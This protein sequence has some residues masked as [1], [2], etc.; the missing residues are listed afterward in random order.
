MP[1]GAATRLFEDIKRAE[2]AAAATQINPASKALPE[3]SSSPEIVEQPKRKTE[4]VVLPTPKR[5]TIPPSSPIA[6]KGRAL[7]AP[8]IDYGL[9]G[10]IDDDDRQ[11]MHSLPIPD[12]MSEVA[13]RIASYVED[14]VA[15][16]IV[17]VDDQVLRR[18]ESLDGR[19]DQLE[20]MIEARFQHLDK[21]LGH[22]HNIIKNKLNAL[23]ATV[24]KLVERFDAPPPVHSTA[25]SASGTPPPTDLA[26][27]TTGFQL[28]NPEGHVGVNVS[29]SRSPSPEPDE[30]Q[31]QHPIVVVKVTPPTPSGSQDMNNVI[32]ST[33]PPPPPTDSGKLPEPD[34]PTAPEAILQISEAEPT[35]RPDSPIPD[36]FSPNNTPPANPA[37]ADADQIEPEDKMDVDPVGNATT[38]GNAE[39]DP[40]VTITKESSVEPSS[41]DLH[42]GPTA[43]GMVGNPVG[44]TITG[45]ALEPPTTKLLTPNSPRC[46]PRLQSDSGTTFR[47]R[48]RSRSRSPRPSPSHNEQMES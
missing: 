14:S 36:G 13:Q 43:S 12:L 41:T 3:R 4:R 45:R 47:S 21:M 17:E 32:V 5:V 30:S 11:H 27:D 48:S 35:P 46:S 39:Q 9:P 28:A 15:N 26:D 1:S 33:A 8:R 31:L 37:N 44:V 20:E 23:Q 42:A 10:V 29:P 38:P 24:D 40:V 16:T 22:S 25:A 7:P 18:W 2:V 19:L 6:P 34:A